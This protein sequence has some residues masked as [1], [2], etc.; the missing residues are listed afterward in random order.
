MKSGMVAAETAFA[1]LT[2]LSTSRA[3]DLKGYEAALRDSWVWDELTAVRN[4]RPGCAA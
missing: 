3:I 4:I 1:A 2:T